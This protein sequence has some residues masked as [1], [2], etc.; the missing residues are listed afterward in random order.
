MS[1]PCSSMS[2]SKVHACYHVPVAIVRPLTA[3]SVEV[4]P[5]TYAAGR[6]RTMHRSVQSVQGISLGKS[7]W[8]LVIASEKHSSIRRVSSGQPHILSLLDL[9]RLAGGSMVAVGGFDST[10]P[11][12]A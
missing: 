6:L 12:R 7:T 2:P 8:S 11:A 10:L 5:V 3:A 1:A 4:A 9:A